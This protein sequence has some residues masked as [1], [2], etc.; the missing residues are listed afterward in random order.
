MDKE[1]LEV[2][3]SESYN[4]LINAKTARE[5]IT[6][7]VRNKW[8][9]ANEQEPPEHA[10]PTDDNMF[11]FFEENVVKPLSEGERKQ[12]KIDA[13][14]FHFF[15]LCFID[16]RAWMNV[17]PYWHAHRAWVDEGESRGKH[18]WGD[19]ID[20]W[21][22]LHKPEIRA[23][24]YTTSIMPTALG[25]VLEVTFDSAFIGEGAD[26]RDVDMNE[27][28]GEAKQANLFDTPKDRLPLR[29]LLIKGLPPVDHQGQVSQRLRVF[30]EVYIATTGHYVHKNLLV[31]F[32]FDHFRRALYPGW[33]G[34]R[35][36]TR[37]KDRLRQTI[38]DM[39]K[40]YLECP[41]LGPFA[42]IMARTP[43]ENLSRAN[44]AV[45]FD[46]L[47]PIEADLR[48]GGI[49]QTQRMRELGFRGGRGGEAKYRLY[50]ALA[51]FWDRH[52]T[53]GGKIIWPTRPKVRR[54]AKGNIL[55]KHGKPLLTKAG[56]QSTTWR[57]GEPVL[58][59]QG[60][61]QYEPN[62]KALAVYPE[63]SRV[64]LQRFI[65][66]RWDVC[67]EI[68]REMEVEGIFVLHERSDGYQIL[69]SVSH[70]QAY[71]RVAR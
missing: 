24:K 47:F 16:D 57:R 33:D 54:D 28:A 36:E 5:A 46:V 53:R 69:P 10:Q 31:K 18:P 13:Q 61:P 9:Q 3:K 71:G 41:R 15:F 34:G 59:R 65:G 35:F 14:Y 11:R 52:G 19:A 32:D 20:P 30:H 58:D 60:N 7:L 38:D 62:P 70:C 48:R 22:E 45:V 68:L 40:A 67:A 4:D 25:S 12:E 49:I 2:A 1:Q 21:I 66:Q 64:E 17:Y 63:I 37:N 44:D 55:D 26:R 23:K 51:Q 8:L 27:W 43:V 56:K 6:A 29:Q 50:H 39:R 42:P